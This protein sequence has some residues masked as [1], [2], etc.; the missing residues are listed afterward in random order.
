VDTGPLV[1]ILDAGDASH[2]RCTAFM[3]R[4]R[5]RLVTTWP[6]VTQAMYLLE[7][8]SVQ[9][10]LLARI[11]SG[12][13]DIADILGQTDRMASLMPQYQDMPMDFADASQVAVAERKGTDTIFTLDD[14]FRMY[15]LSGRRAFRVVP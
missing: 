10:A 4:D 14:D 7:T 3:A 6:V 9:T 12:T 1:A 8:P 2:A 13:L 5:R 15:R 11:V